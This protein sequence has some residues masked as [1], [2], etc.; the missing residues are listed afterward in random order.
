MSEL[1]N[2]FHER[3]MKCKEKCTDDILSLRESSMMKSISDIYI[4]VDANKQIATG[5]VM[6]TLAIAKQVRKL[7]G[8]CK[9]IVA[10]KYAISSIIDNDFEVICLN[11]K[12]NDLNQEI[13]QMQKLI[14]E[15]QIKVLLVDSYFVTEEYLNS[16]SNKTYVAYIDDLNLFKYPVNTI[17]NYATYYEAF[18]YK[19]LNYDVD[20]RFLLGTQ[21]VPLREE[22]SQLLRKKKEVLKNILIT[23]GGTDQYHV[24]YLLLKQLIESKMIDN[25]TL[26]I[27]MG[28]FNEDLEMINKLAAHRENIFLYKNIDY[29]SKLMMQCD[30][31]ISAGGTTLF[32][33]CA[34]GLPTIS[35][36]IAD[37]QLQGINSLAEKGYM[38]TVGDIRNN[39]D[40]GILEIVNKLKYYL[41]NPQIGH[42]Y[43]VKMQQLIDGRGAERIAKYLL[44]DEKKEI[45]LDMP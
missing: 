29:M 10:D 33:L 21:Y 42:Q 11:S 6:R 44:Q 23:T 31:A 24:T 26:H 2:L 16:L 25:L 18:D 1:R 38:L 3:Y 45:R 13:V 5:H 14:T 9:F 12:W 15:E 39:I 35:F 4:R 19:S 20:T 7:G 36:G 32:E 22:F 28:R 27:V 37:N 30:L 34:C 8:R 41:N 43:S 40:I 17:I